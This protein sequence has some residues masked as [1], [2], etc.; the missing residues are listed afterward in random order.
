MFESIVTLIINLCLFLIKKI[1]IINFQCHVLLIVIC[2]HECH[3]FMAA[4]LKDD[5]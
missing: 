3:H 2:R 1:E 5:E 4:N